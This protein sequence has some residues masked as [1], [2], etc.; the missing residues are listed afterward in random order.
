M[1]IRPQRGGRIASLRLAGEELL[2]RGIGV[3]DPHALGFVEAGAWGWD[4]MV[5]NVAATDSLP[6][7]GE[8]WRLP[9]EVMRAAGIEVALRC[10]GL[11]V[12][13]E[14]VRSVYL[15]EALIAIYTYRN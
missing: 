13:W 1:E 8:A 2:D 3:D 9:W 11:V 12:P 4:E 14:L 15:R 10:R 5:P 7:H 6:D